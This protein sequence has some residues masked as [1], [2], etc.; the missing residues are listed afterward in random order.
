MSVENSLVIGLAG[1]ILIL[2]VSLAILLGGHYGR[3]E[4]LAT[5]KVGLFTMLTFLCAAAQP[6]RTPN[7]RRRSDPRTNDADRMT[8][9]TYR[10]S[11]GRVD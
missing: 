11:P 3:I 2:G 5:I 6:A 7:R 4:K 10:R 9:A 1:S 8:S